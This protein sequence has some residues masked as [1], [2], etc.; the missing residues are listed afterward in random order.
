MSTVDD[1]FELKSESGSNKF[2]GTLMGSAA[3]A[4]RAS[5][6][7]PVGTDREYCEK[8]DTDFVGVADE[9]RD[10]IIFLLN[11]IAKFAASDLEIKSYEDIQELIEGL[12]ETADLRLDAAQGVDRIGKRADVLVSRHTL[13]AQEAKNALLQSSIL[14]KP[15]LRFDTNDIDNTRHRPFPQPQQLATYY[16]HPYQAE[17]ELLSYPPWQLEDASDLDASASSI[18]TISRLTNDSSHPFQYVSDVLALNAAVSE[19]VT[20]HELAVDVEHHSMHSFLGLTCL[21]QISTREKDYIID[22][23]AIRTADA[24]ALQSL[25]KAFTNP[26]IVKIFH[27][28]NRD[29]LW[30]QRDCGLYLQY[31]KLSLAYLMQKFLRIIPN[32]EYQQ[33]DWRQRP[34]SA[35]MIQYARDD[36]HYLHFIYDCLRRELGG[37]EAYRAVLDRSRDVCLNRYE[38]PFFDPEGYKNLQTTRRLRGSSTRETQKAMSAEQQQCMRGLW[39]WRD[40]MARALDESPAYLL[41]TAELVQICENIPSSVDM[42]KKNLQKKAGV[43]LSSHYDEVFHAIQ[44]SVAA[45]AAAAATAATATAVTAVTTSALLQP[46]RDTSI[47]TAHR[48]H[49]AQTLPESVL[50]V[51][52][53]VTPTPEAR[54]EFTAES[55]GL[56][57]DLRIPETSAEWFSKTQIHQPRTSSELVDQLKKTGTHPLLESVISVSISVNDRFKLVA[58]SIQNIVT[59][60]LV[61]PEASSTTAD[62]VN[63]EPPNKQESATIYTENEKKDIETLGTLAVELVNDSNIRKRSLDEVNVP[64]EAC[65]SNNLVNLKPNKKQNR[66]TAAM[67]NAHKNFLRDA[68]SS[69]G[70]HNPNTAQVQTQIGAIQ[71]QLAT[72]LSDFKSSQEKEKKKKEKEGKKLIRLQRTQATSVMSQ[73]SLPDKKSKKMKKNPYFAVGDVEKAP[74]KDHQRSFTY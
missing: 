31:P 11:R 18:D 62:A 73:A 16:E 37:E 71:P 24:T 36:T 35:E 2:I 70:A 63:D 49:F 64:D 53:V 32:K 46:S 30:L 43:Y 29:V 3:G 19:M 55:K 33:A 51:L 26:N 41:S 20:Y 68:S 45:P 13:S 42:L 23:L 56:F 61:R 54:D 25:N 10:D 9:C 7:L 14:Q 21:L 72:A 1:V 38:K 50:S 8:T 15:Q 5:N 47:L 39:D 6:I 48:D 58:Q 65:T 44:V 60:L 52:P 74:P 4:V 17:L 67:R 59:P 27:G 57:A 40:G 12:L 69:S 34:L 28:S 22:T 66:N